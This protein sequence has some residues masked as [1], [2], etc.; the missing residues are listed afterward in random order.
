MGRDEHGFSDILI[1]GVG[2]SIAIAIALAPQLAF[3]GNYEAGVPA[4]KAPRWSNDHHIRNS[5]IAG[6]DCVALPPGWAA[7][8]V[9]GR[10]AWGNPVAPA[11]NHTG[12]VN[13]LPIEVDVHLGT[14]K[15]GKKR[16]DLYTGPMIYDPA[17]GTANTYPLERDCV[18]H[19]K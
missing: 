19:F 14:K 7:D 2:L 10:D 17:Q 8:Y 13:T 5:V 1:Y 4:P 11:D 18:P 3:S 15:F 16:V 9:P 12:Y 6:P